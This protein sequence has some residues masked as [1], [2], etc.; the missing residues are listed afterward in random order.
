MLAVTDYSCFLRKMRR[1]HFL[2]NSLPSLHL[3]ELLPHLRRHHIHLPLRLQQ[4][5]PPFR[6]LTIARQRLRLVAVPR[7]RVLQIHDHA[8]GVAER[9]Q[10]HADAVDHVHVTVLLAVDHH[11]QVVGV[12]PDRRAHARHRTHRGPCGFAVDRT[13]GVAQAD[14]AR[15]IARHRIDVL[16]GRLRI[17]RHQRCTRAGHMGRCRVGIDGLPGLLRARLFSRGVGG[18]ALAGGSAD[19]DRAGQRETERQVQCFPTPASSRGFHPESPPPK[20]RSRE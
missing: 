3:L 8:Q 7:L 5:P 6:Q 16:L 18:L 20:R 15:E 1:V 17:A 10:R 2:I 4:R 12:E 9:L 19:G 11:G 13:A 14:R